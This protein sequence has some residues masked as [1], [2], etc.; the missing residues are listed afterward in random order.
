MAA[1]R[2]TL[3]ELEDADLLIH[4]V[5]LADSDWEERMEA[6]DGILTDL[7]LGEV[8]RLVVFN[9]ID[10]LPGDTPLEGLTRR[11]DAVCVSALDSSTLRPLS[12]RILSTFEGRGAWGRERDVE[13]SPVSP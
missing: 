1:F 2:A 12:E 8:S 7:D 5:D 10:K 11:F 6:V 3:E 9:K 4:V 13:P